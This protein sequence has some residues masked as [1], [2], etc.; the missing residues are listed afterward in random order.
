MHFSAPYEPPP[1]QP[2]NSQ[3]VRPY[4]CPQCPDGYKLVTSGGLASSTARK[5]LS[6][7]EMAGIFIVQV[8]ISIS[9]SL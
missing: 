2:L 3:R 4:L 8:R 6:I 7:D 9:Q 5:Q 1:T